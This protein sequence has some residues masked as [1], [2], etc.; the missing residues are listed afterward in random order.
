VYT[1]PPYTGPNGL[2]AGASASKKNPR[3]TNKFPYSATDHTQV[4]AIEVCEKDFTSSTLQN[5]FKRML[6][7]CGPSAPGNKQYYPTMP[8]A[9]N[10]GELGAINTLKFVINNRGVEATYILQIIRPSNFKW[11]YGYENAICDRVGACTGVL[12]Y[13]PAKI[14]PFACV[15]LNF[16]KSDPM[17]GYPITVNTQSKIDSDTLA[18]CAIPPS[19]YQICQVV[20]QDDTVGGEICPPPPMPVPNSG[21][22]DSM[23]SGVGD[24]T[25]ITPQGSGNLNGGGLITTTTVNADGTITTTTTPAAGSSTQP[26]GPGSTP[27]P[28]HSGTT[29]T[30]R[31]SSNLRI[32]GNANNNGNFNFQDELR[33][34]GIPTSTGFFQVKFKNGVSCDLALRFEL[35]KQCLERELNKP[36]NH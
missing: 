20:Q 35:V 17:S 1:S 31:H 7:G 23:L 6:T 4:A 24:L 36:E 22:D 11:D 33:A 32:A 25:T 13:V 9:P 10:V 2:V 29:S 18:K 30:V 19:S 5:L 16:H 21:Y 28:T 26:G 34:L 14:V 12:G 3:T 27:T 8:L 15:N